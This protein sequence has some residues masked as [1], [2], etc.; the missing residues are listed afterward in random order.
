M[1]LGV[2]LTVLLALPLN[3]PNEVPFPC[4]VR[5]PVV[6]NA[7]L[8]FPLASPVAAPILLGVIV[9]VVLALLLNV[10]NGVD[11]SEPLIVK[12]LCV[13]VWSLVA[14]PIL[15]GVI[16]TVLV[17]LPSNTAAWVPLV[18]IVKALLTLFALI[19]APPALEEPA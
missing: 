13:W 16:L 3:V 19:A 8:A 12:V 1:L 10:P 17:E 15:S 18:C 7:L 14:A 2:I 11:S 6:F 4:I 9:I 5:A